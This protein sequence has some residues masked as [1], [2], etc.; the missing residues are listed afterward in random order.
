MRQGLDVITLVLGGARSGKS[1]V[2]EDIA[3]AWGA[4]TYVATLDVGADPDLAARVALH[5]ARRD[6]RWQTIEAGRDLVNSIRAVSGPVLVDSLGPWVS[7]HLED[8]VDIAGLC[9]ALT[10]RRADAVVVS[11][12]VGLS[13][14]PSTE[15]GRRF[16]D[17]LGSVNQ[18]VARC[19]GEVLLVVAGRTLR[20][21]AGPER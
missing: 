6:P 13:V 3:T 17:V 12:E 9:R 20:L 7:A 11:E 14:H 2:A 18:A 16:R 1:A 21:D 10:D 19:A 5:R 8:E 4:I 15:V